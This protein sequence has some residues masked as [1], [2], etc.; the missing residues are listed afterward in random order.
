MANNPYGGQQLMMY[1]PPQAQQQPQAQPPQ[2][3]FIGVNAMGMPITA[4][5]NQ[6]AA[7]AAQGMYFGAPAPA[8]A[9]AFQDPGVPLPATSTALI[10]ETRKQHTDAQQ[11]IKKKTTIESKKEEDR[12]SQRMTRKEQSALA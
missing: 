6:M 11:V 1:Q 8:P 12:L 4:D 7:A 10:M 9:P 5:P 2:Q 3:Q